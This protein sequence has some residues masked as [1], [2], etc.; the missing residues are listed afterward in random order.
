V[1]GVFILPASCTESL[2]FPLPLQVHESHDIDA[3]TLFLM[4]K[5]EENE[6]DK[7][8]LKENRGQEGNKTANQTMKVVNG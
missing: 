1:H 8:G 5:G 4:R 2:L 3:Q 6:E 7:T